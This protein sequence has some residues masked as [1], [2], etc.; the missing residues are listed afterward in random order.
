[1]VSFITEQTLPLR[2]LA[3]ML[4]GN[5][6]RHLHYETL[7]RWW[8]NGVRGIHLETRPFGGKRVS[9]M[10]AIDR[11]MHHLAALEV[12]PEDEPIVTAPRLTPEDR[13]S[14]ER[15]RNKKNF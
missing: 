7:R 9:S 10:E 13:Q 1:M 11:F 12:E 8:R 6:G 2:Q 3:L 15:C 14:L 5:S 4:P